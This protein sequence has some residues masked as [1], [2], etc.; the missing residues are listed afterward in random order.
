[1][2]GN[3]NGILCK[4]MSKYLPKK[5]GV[6]IKKVNDFFCLPVLL[7]GALMYIKGRFAN[8]IVQVIVFHTYSMRIESC[9][10]VGSGDKKDE[11]L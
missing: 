9:F 4:Y 2:M 6:L 10:N 3:F 5:F 7:L 1:M 8:S 11:Y